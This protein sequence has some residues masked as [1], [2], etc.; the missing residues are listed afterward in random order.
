MAVFTRVALTAFPGIVAAMAADRGVRRDR[1]DGARLVR[2]DRPAQHQ[3]ADGLFLDRPY[4]L[5][6]GRARAGTPEGVQGVLVYMAIYVAMTLGTF[7]VHP[8]DEAQ[9]PAWSR[10]SAISPACRAPIPA[11][12]SS[13]RCC[14]SRSP[15]FRRSRASSQILRVPRRDQGGLFTLAVIGVLA[16]VVGAYYYLRIIKVMYFDEPAPASSR[17]AWNCARCWRSRACST[18]C[19]S[20][21]RGRWSASHGAAK[22]LF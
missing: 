19:S 21:I 22:S 6:A 16:S 3:A 17:C 9:R 15:A 14:C 1:L 4:G 11:W 10:T 18:S 13:S 7:A 5:R 2:R 20:S 12:R 8:V